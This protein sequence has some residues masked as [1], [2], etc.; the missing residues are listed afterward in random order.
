MEDTPSNITKLPT[1]R[2]EIQDI[3]EE[4][5]EAESKIDELERQFTLVELVALAPSGIDIAEACDQIKRL[6]LEKNISYG[7]S[8]LS[9][10]NIFAKDGA[11][12][13]IAHRI[14]DKLN[15]IKNNQEFANENDLD[16][17][18]GYLILYKIAQNV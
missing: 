13:G 11:A 17:L 15:R 5:Q 1:R 3:W 12:G 2:N 18:L 6:L 16:D 4:I 7:N 9:P 14:D 8:A 10:I